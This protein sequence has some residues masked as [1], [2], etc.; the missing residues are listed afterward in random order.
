VPAGKQAE[1][2]TSLVA[3]AWQL[4]VNRQQVGNILQSVSMQLVETD[5]RGKDKAKGYAGWPPA[6][7]GLN[8]SCYTSPHTED[9]GHSRS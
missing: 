8:G 2:C 4:T 9:T 5:G 1:A 6:G 3:V 7:P